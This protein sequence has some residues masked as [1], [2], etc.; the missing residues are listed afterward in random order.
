MEKATST[1]RSFQEALTGLRAT[2]IAEGIPSPAEILHGRS[3]TTRKAISVDLNAVRQHLIQLQAKYIKQHDKA[4]GQ[5]HRALV[6]GEE[7][8]HLSTGNNW[9]IGIISGTRDS[10]RSYDVLTE[11]GTS[12]RR[13]RSH[14]KP[15]SHNIHVL[16]KAFISGPHTPSQSEISGSSISGPAHL[17][18]RNI[19]SVQQLAIPF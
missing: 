14:L 10:G 16:N 7:V 17:P 19:L 18:K 8:Y 13:N 2:P 11:G 9:V 1:G 6:I 3:L 15:R 12:L 4:D 5:D